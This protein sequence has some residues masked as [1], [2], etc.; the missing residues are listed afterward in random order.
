YIGLELGSV[1]SRLGSKVTVLE[2]L[3]R[4]LPLSDGEI[5]GLL[6]KS[7]A[8]QGLEFHLETRVT[9]AKKEA[10]KVTVQAEAAGKKL[11]FKGDK[12]LVSVGRRAVTQDLGLEEAGVKFDSKSGKVAVN[13]RFETNIPGVFAIGDLIDGPMLA[14]KASHEGVA[15]AENLAGKAGHINYHAIPSVIYTAP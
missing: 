5:A 4:L 7:L 12:V 6:Q 15:F 10:G 2:F 8:K 3:P 9:G 11:D 14:H 13:E 1:W